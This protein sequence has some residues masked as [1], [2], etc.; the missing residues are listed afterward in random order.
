MSPIKVLYVLDAFEGGARTGGT[1]AQLIELLSR[2]DRRRFSPQVAV[3]RS[4]GWTE[5]GDAFPCPSRVLGVGKLRDPRSAVRLLGLAGLV[6]REGVQL[7]HVLLND[8]SI[9]APFFCRLGG[10]RVIVSRRDMGFWYT[11]GILAA[12]RV[13]NVFVERIVANSQAVRRNVHARE[14]YP[15]SRVDVVYNGHNPARFAAPAASGLRERLGIGPADPIVGAVAN[16][17]PWKRHTDL[18]QAFARVRDRHPRTR[19][20]LVGS[21]ELQQTLEDEAQRLGIAGAVHFLGATA[22]VV[23][24]VKHFTIGVLC[25][26]S[27]GLSNAVIEYM[28]CGKPSICTSVGGNSEVIVDGETGFL[29]PP[30]DV[31]VLTD[32]LDRLLSDPAL[33]EAMGDRARCAA[34]VLTSDRMAAQHMDLYE[35]VAATRP[36]SLH[37]RNAQAGFG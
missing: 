27:E 5:S 16:L 8:A 23:S 29:I 6:R 15:A 34:G 14:R 35:R 21:G 20:L 22:D 28:T 33:A 17:N 11:P 36:L 37:N 10:A 30:G 19:L 1:E 7:V 25:S 4:T 31:A 26:E 18:L 32:R 2:L 9:V 24:I 3:F 12:L 13:S